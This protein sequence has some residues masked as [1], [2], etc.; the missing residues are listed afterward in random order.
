M[1]HI[2]NVT[3]SSPPDLSQPTEVSWKSHGNSSLQVWWHPPPLPPDVAIHHYLV[4]VLLR[5]T[6][7]PHPSWDPPRGECGSLRR[8]VCILLSSLSG[9]I[10]M[11]IMTIMIYYYYRY[12][13]V[14]VTIIYC[15]FHN[16]G[17]Y[18]RKRRSH[19]DTPHYIFPC[20][21][22]PQHLSAS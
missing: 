5:P 10:G 15:N 13:V 19:G 16:F 8:R 17:F 11:M 9:N 18:I 2:F 14:E 20:V 22:T 3:T 7:P 12:K 21:V 6:P 1:F 4:T